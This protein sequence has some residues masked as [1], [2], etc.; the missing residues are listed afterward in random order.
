MVCLTAMQAEGQTFTLQHKS[1]SLSLL[2][3]ESSENRDVWKLPYPTFAFATGDVNG[4][5]VTDALVGVVKPTRFDPRMA[6]RLFVF[7]QIHDYVRPLWLGSRLAGE[8]FDFAFGD[9]QLTTLEQETDRSWFVG[10]YRWDHFGFVM[11]N[12]PL[13]HATRHEAEEK[14]EQ[15]KNNH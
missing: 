13:R 5:G 12:C 6:R 10:T 8:L 9:G 2:V 7:Q 4:D 11:T 15:L 1:D 14:F 3:L